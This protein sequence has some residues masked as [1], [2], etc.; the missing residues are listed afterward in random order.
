MCSV[1]VVLFCVAAAA[2]VVIRTLACG[3]PVSLIVLCCGGIVA[4]AIVV[5]AIRQLRHCMHCSE[6]SD[7][8]R[9][10]I[11]FTSICKKAPEDDA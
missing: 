1:F 6:Y 10:F 4:L 9:L 5:D 7:C 2:L 8:S 3:D 11:P